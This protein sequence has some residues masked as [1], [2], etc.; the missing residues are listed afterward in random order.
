MDHNCNLDSKRFRLSQHLS[1]DHSLRL[2]TLSFSYHLSTVHKRATMASIK[3][4]PSA[5]SCSCD[6]CSAGD[7]DLSCEA[8]DPDRASDFLEQEVIPAWV[9][10]RAQVTG[11][12]SGRTQRKIGTVFLFRRS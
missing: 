1:A 8:A 12:Y 4:L 3:N 11:T 2:E 9:V 5:S 7:T 6:L 10:K